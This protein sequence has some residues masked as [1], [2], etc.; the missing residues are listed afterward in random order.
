MF[1][2]KMKNPRK[3]EYPT[4]RGYKENLENLQ[5]LPLALINIKINF[6]TTSMKRNK[7]IKILFLKRLKIM[8]TKK[9]LKPLMKKILQPLMKMKRKIFLKL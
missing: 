1:K 9:I 5:L 6:M 4:F 3:L 2:Q 8:L 7:E